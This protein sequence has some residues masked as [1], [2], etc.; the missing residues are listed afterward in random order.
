[1]MIRDPDGSSEV[2]EPVLCHE[3]PFRHICPTEQRHATK[4]IMEREGAIVPQDEEAKLRG[5]G[6]LARKAAENCPIR[7]FVFR[8]FQGCC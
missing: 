2:F 4:Y 3:C 5:A 1:M 7:Q 8:L 6:E